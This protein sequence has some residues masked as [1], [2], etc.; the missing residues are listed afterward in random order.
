MA[1][2]VAVEVN[3]FWSCVMFSCWEFPSL[4]RGHSQADLYL[5]IFDHWYDKWDTGPNG[6][7]CCQ[8][9][10]A[11]EKDADYP[12]FGQCVCSPEVLDGPGTDKGKLWFWPCCTVPCLPQEHRTMVCVAHVEIP[13]ASFFH[14]TLKGKITGNISKGPL[15]LP[16]REIESWGLVATSFCS[17]KKLMRNFFWC[18]CLQVFTS[19][20]FSAS[21]SPKN[22]KIMIW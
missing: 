6:Y 21:W 8:L 5:I 13:T 20:P 7:Q 19:T 15:F 3:I 14:Y 1:F 2:P 12:V 17:E 18:D 11:A 4:F 10:C 9:V 16:K 22:P